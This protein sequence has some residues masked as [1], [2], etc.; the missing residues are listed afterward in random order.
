M[1]IDALNGRIRHPI[2][3]H[4]RLASSTILDKRTFAFLRKS[5]SLYP[6]LV[7]EFFDRLTPDMLE[8]LKEGKVE[9]LEMAIR[10]G[11]HNAVRVIGDRV[12][13]KLLPPG[14]VLGFAMYFEQ[15]KALLDSGEDMR[16]RTDSLLNEMLL[17]SVGDPEKV[18]QYMIDEGW[19]KDPSAIGPDVRERILY[20]FPN[21]V[22]K[23]LI[24]KI[25]DASIARGDDPEVWLN[26]A[27]E[28]ACEVV[29][30]YCFDRKIPIDAN[31]LIVRRIE[32]TD[33]EE[34]DMP[35]DFYF[36][37]LEEWGG[38][39]KYTFDRV[40]PQTQK[41]VRHSFMSYA[42]SRELIDDVVFFVEM[43]DGPKI[44]PEAIRALRK[45]FLTDDKE[46]IWKHMI[47][48]GCDPNA[49]DEDGW[50]TLHW[51]FVTTPI[52]QLIE[53][54]VEDFAVRRLIA[55]GAKVNLPGG[56]KGQTPLMLVLQHKWI[57]HNTEWVEILL[58][59]GADPKIKDSD[60]NDAFWY[61]NTYHKKKGGLCRDIL[62]LMKHGA[63]SCES[64]DSE[65][66]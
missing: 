48:H 3:R 50:P 60:G 5:E 25:L 59:R 47:E 64:D 33:P 17:R 40:D 11:S 2:G 21:S 39:V 18:L 15:F 1:T 16:S 6:A 10:V 13:F 26:T 56:P 41:I 55:A 4:I 19:L 31:A 35:E 14:I 7:M 66:W 63:G 24:Y 32:H 62:K 52:F 46:Q 36:R 54:H 23:H 44:T 30:E 45:M 61:A 65:D 12:S 38:D 34:D 57:W 58:R 49:P 8:G 9:L 51:I 28:A 22:Q 42:A 29:V 37:L 20:S 53:P 27:A 43:E